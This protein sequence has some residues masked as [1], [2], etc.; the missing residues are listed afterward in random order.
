MMGAA[1]T[2]HRHLLTQ[3]YPDALAVLRREEFHA[4][5]FKGAAHSG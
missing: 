3:S 5:V 1:S 2:V 4:S